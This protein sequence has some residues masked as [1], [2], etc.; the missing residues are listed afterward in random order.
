MEKFITDPALINTMG[1]A[2]RQIA[3]GKFDVHAV[4]NFML[5]EMGL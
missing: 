4:N 1:K 3:E 5:K 2:S